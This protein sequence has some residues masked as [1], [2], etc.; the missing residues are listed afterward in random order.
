MA[1]CACCGHSYRPEAIAPTPAPTIPAN[2]GTSTTTRPARACPATIG[3]AAA[4]RLMRRRSRA[5]RPC[6]LLDPVSFPT[7]V[8][9]RSLI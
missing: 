6:R 4:A 5:S 3:T 1:V 2:C 9:D 7:H 8:S